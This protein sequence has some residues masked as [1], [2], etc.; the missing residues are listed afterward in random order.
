MSD[1]EKTN[2]RRDPFSEHLRQRLINEPTLPDANCW[3]EIEA[4]LP[5]KRVMSPLWIGLAV[6]ASIVVAVFVLNDTVTENESPF[7]DEALVLKENL[8]EKETYRGEILHEEEGFEAALKNVHEDV[9]AEAKPEKNAQTSSSVG[10]EEKDANSK[11]KGTEKIIQDTAE[12][13]KLETERTEKYI[14]EAERAENVAESIESA[15]ESKKDDFSAQK[16]QYQNSENL[17]AHDENLSA[18]DT[19]LK[20][21]NENLTAYDEGL[22]AY[23]EDLRPHDESPTARDAYQK[24]SSK[25]GKN[26]LMLAGLGSAGGLGYLLSSLDGYDFLSDGSPDYNSG[27]GTI[28]DPVNELGIGSGDKNSEYGP[29]EEIT[30]ISTSVPISFGFTVRKKINKAIGIETGLLYTYLSSE[31]KISGVDYNGATLNLHYI[32]IPVNLTVNMMDKKRWSIYASGGGMVDKGLQ[33]VYKKNGA[34]GKKRS[35]ISGL[36]WS[37][38][39]G[40]GISYNLYNNM[41]LYVEPGVSYYFDCNQPISKRTEDPFNFNLR[42]GLRYDI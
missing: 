21:Y 26:R 30:D 10:S 31:L 29:K 42:L 2:D 7:Y 17:A 8:V 41:N 40:I 23:N 11:H 15:E 32:G 12:D 16:P 24:R 34:G 20:A 35:H 4:R 1:Y 9:I 25:K 22:K 39:S 18:R 27:E 13:K 28:K 6:A 5:K 3:D 14:K 19:D 38:N 37:L 33:S 36:Q